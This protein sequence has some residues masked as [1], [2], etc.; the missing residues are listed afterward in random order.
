MAS[1]LVRPL[2]PSP[3]PT[4]TKPIIPRPVIRI[5]QPTTP[6]ST[7]SNSASSGSSQPQSD[8]FNS[9]MGGLSIRGSVNSVTSL[10]NSSPNPQDEYKAHGRESGYLVSSQ[11]TSFTM[12]RGGLSSTTFARPKTVTYEAFELEAVICFI[13]R[14]RSYNETIKSGELNERKPLIENFINVFI[15]YG[16]DK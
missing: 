1:T 4:P 3:S 9:T 14:S 16:C 5:K 6:N 13:A 10:P 7:I 2:K 11:F 12:S 15:N 8:T